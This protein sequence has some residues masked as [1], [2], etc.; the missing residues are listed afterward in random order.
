MLKGKLDTDA[1]LAFGSGVAAKLRAVCGQGSR[2]ERTDASI[3]AL[4]GLIRLADVGED[5]GGYVDREIAAFLFAGP[6]PRDAFPHVAL[7]GMAGAYRLAQGHYLRRDRGTA[8]LEQTVRQL[9][10]EHKRTGDGAFCLPAP[11]GDGVRVESL[12]SVCPFL[13]MAAVALGDAPLHDEAVRHYLGVEAALLDETTGLFHHARNWRRPGAVT[14]DA[15][16]RGN[17][18]AAAALTEML[19][20]LP[21]THPQ[22]ERLISRLADLLERLVALQTERGLW[23]QELA[24]PDAYE[25]VSGSALIACALATALNEGWLPDRFLPAAERA[26]RGL[27][28]SVDTETN[29]NVADVCVDT[30]PSEELSHYLTRPVATNDPNAFGPLLLAAVAFYELAR[31][32][33]WA[34]AAA[35]PEPFGKPDEAEVVACFRRAH[36]ACEARYNGDGSWGEGMMDAM[37]TPFTRMNSET[38]TSHPLIRRSGQCV[39]GYLSATAGI[40]DEFFTLRARE[41]LDWLIAEQ[42]PDGS[43]RLYT[44]KR[45]GQVDHN[46]CLFVTGIAGAALARGYEDF[47]DERYLEASARTARW[48]AEWPP[49]VNVNFNSFAVW[50]LAEHYRLTGDGA[51]LD[52]AIRK[53]RLRILPPQ[54]PS[55]GWR[56]HNSWVWY[57]GIILRGHAAL[58]R[59]LPE[60]HPLRP[61]LR[62]ATLAAA[63]YFVR[64]QTETGAIY[65]NPE[66][67]EPSAAVGYAI[68]SLSLCVTLFDDPALETALRGFVQY[69]VSPESGDVDGSYNNEQKTTSTGHADTVLYAIGA[70]IEARQR[71]KRSG[72]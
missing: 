28:A 51:A 66:T 60:S 64:L 48:E 63:R 59:A 62:D 35:P 42:E 67:R 72:P 49:V 50:H 27:V 54:L 71:A 23:R 32:K 46:G 24:D 16:A 10:R 43:F 8:L 45:E 52:A 37:E 39:L 68:A 17:G 29:W 69:R 56:G 6:S 12:L 25:E 30:E 26:W 2:L 41:G 44:R 65:P 40:E 36:E 61:E 70:Y 7:G 15:W 14:P 20:F 53:T 3:L 11:A 9:L 4:Y 33:E 38:R 34:R 31:R 47:G 5:Y 18:C 58:Y 55:G 22:R 19:R 57:H 21:A 13:C 1:A